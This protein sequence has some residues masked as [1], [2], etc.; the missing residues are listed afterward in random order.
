YFVLK[1][2]YP[3]NHA[4]LEQNIKEH[5]KWRNSNRHNSLLKMLQKK[6]YVI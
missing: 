4:E 5:L 1:S 2:S 6:T 3:V